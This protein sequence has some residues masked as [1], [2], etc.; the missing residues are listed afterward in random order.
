MKRKRKRYKNS[1]IIIF[2]WNYF[3]ENFLNDKCTIHFLGMFFFCFNDIMHWAGMNLMILMT[4]QCSKDLLNK[5]NFIKNPNSF[6]ARIKSQGLKTIITQLVRGGSLVL[7]DGVCPSI[8]SFSLW[9]SNCWS[10]M[11]FS[12]SCSKFIRDIRPPLPAEA[13]AGVWKKYSTVKKLKDEH[14]CCCSS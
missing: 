3:I 1:F 12:A 13:V 10:S 5:H 4:S 6:T 8:S 7:D 9:I 11:I 2:I 14:L